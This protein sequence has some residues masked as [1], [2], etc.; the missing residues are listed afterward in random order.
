MIPIVV[1]ALEPVL[2]GLE[3]KK[4]EG[5]VKVEEESRLYRQHYCFKIDKNT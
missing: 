4:I 2:K 5:I 1:G 3:K